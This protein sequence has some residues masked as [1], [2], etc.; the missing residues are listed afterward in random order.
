MTPTT[1]T[2]SG[3]TEA[4]S[5]YF[6]TRCAHVLKTGHTY[7]TFD[8]NYEEDWVNEGG[9]RYSGSVHITYVDHWPD[10]TGRRQSRKHEVYVGSSPIEF[11]RELLDNT[12]P[13][14]IPEGWQRLARCTNYREDLDQPCDGTLP[15]GPD[16]IEA[17]C[18]TC[19]ARC[20]YMVAEYLDDKPHHQI[21]RYLVTAAATGN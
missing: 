2:A 17:A 16:D 4:L 18:G 7:D 20:G 14:T 21:T 10:S 8:L 19:G 5:R 15:Y 6:H 3:F 9:A 12:T 11:M 13:S 1:P